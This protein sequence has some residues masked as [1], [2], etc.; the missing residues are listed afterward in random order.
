MGK[1]GER[2]RERRKIREGLPVVLLVDRGYN[3]LIFQFCSAVGCKLPDYF[4]SGSR[5]FVVKGSLYLEY[6]YCKY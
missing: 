1:G 6:S 5:S 3:P 4:S 2:K